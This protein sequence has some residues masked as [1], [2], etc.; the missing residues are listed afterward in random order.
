MV[1]IELHATNVDARVLEMCEVELEVITWT[2]PDIEFINF[3]L[4]ETYNGEGRILK[5]PKSKLPGL[6]AHLDAASVEVRAIEGTT[7]VLAVAVDVPREVFMAA[8]ED[9]WPPCPLPLQLF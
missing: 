4:A 3:Y 1:K 9:G 7:V 2:R 5:L 8:Q 6:A